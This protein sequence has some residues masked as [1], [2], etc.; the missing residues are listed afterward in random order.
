MSLPGYRTEGFGGL[1]T[2]KTSDVDRKLCG[3]LRAVQTAEV[4]VVE[5]FAG[6]SSFQGSSHPICASFVST[7]STIG[8]NG[9]W[10]LKPS[11][12]C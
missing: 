9:S 10:G 5:Q 3:V 4:V 1:L 8:E 12:P 11:L 2:G 7:I 6:T